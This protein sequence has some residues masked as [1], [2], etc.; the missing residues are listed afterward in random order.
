MNVTTEETKRFLKLVNP[1]DRNEAKKL[2]SNKNVVVINVFTD[3][4]EELYIDAA[5]VRTVKPDG[6][7]DMDNLY[8]VH[9]KNNE[10][11]GDNYPHW[12][13]V[14]SSEENRNIELEKKWK[15]DE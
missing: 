14:V 10:S 1:R 3:A 8:P 12:K 15:V 7:Y 4:D 5:E 13:T 2:I 9:W 6:T 11:K